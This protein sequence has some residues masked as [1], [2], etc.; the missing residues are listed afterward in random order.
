MEPRI[1]FAKRSDGVSIACATIGQG[2]PLVCPP[3]WVSHLEVQWEYEPWRAFYETLAGRHTVVLYDKHGTGLSDRNRTDF[4]LEADRRDLETVVDHLRLKCLALLGL[5]QSGPVAVAYAVKHSRRVTRLILYGTY[6]AGDTIAKDEVKAAILSLIRAHWGVGSKALADVFVPGADAI[7]AQWLAKLQ[8]QSATPEMAAQL[9]ALL[10]QVNV[11]DLLPRLRV[12]TLVIHRQRDR[13]MPFQLGRDL[14]AL[15]PNARFVPLEGDIHVPWLGDADSVVRAIDEFL[16]EGEQAPAVRAAPSREPG[17]LVTILFTDVEGS[18]ALTQRLGDA[19]AREVLREHERI[20]REALKAHGGAEVK[21][22]GDGFMA[23]FSSATGALECAIAMQRAFA[24]HKEAADELIRVRV[25]LNAGE[26]IAEGEDLFGTAVN[27]AARI[28]AQAQG[29]QILVANVVR[30]LAAGKG[31]LFA[32]RGQ[33][34]LRGFEDPVR[35]Y[36]VHWRE[37]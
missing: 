8:R 19:K 6:A 35:L 31:F 21:A 17:G 22:L 33:T 3:G 29:G 26:P 12:P 10:Y 9:L 1:Q 4:S 5:S 7:T 13:A 20:V 32:D 36:E 11:A 2:P 16:G 15:I 37:E 25:G 18:T 30:E 28:A 23:S 14:A 24:A 34:A 27:L